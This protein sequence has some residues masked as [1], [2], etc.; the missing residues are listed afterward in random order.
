MNQPGLQPRIRHGFPNLKTIRESIRLLYQRLTPS[1]VSGFSSDISPND[2]PILLGGDIRSRTQE[3]TD[4]IG[5][6]LGLSKGT[7]VV[8]FQE[9]VGP[10]HVLLSARPPFQ[11]ELNPKYRIEHLDIAAVLAHEMSHVFLHLRGI[12]YSDSSRNEILTDTTAAFLGIGWPCLNAHRAYQYTIERSAGF[13]ARSLET[14]ASEESIGY[15]TPEEFG[16]VLGKRSLITG[17]SV[18]SKI[19][20]GAAK[21]S[22]RKGMKLAKSEFHCPPLSKSSWISKRKYKSNLRVVN[23]QIPSWN[24]SNQ[25]RE[26]PQY[27]FHLSDSVRVQFSCPVCSQGLRLPTQIEVVAVCSL[28]KSSIPCST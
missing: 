5:E 28:C 27:S 8:S 17:N 1:E 14:T 19:D 3:I 18:R 26:F 11:I 24:E 2:V 7:A 23:G 12:G 25:V 20:S 16:Y 21:D 10:A 6:H 22:F 13:G 9:M 15:I 4:K